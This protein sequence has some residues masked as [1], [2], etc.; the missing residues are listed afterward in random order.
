MG[1]YVKRGHTMAESVRL[2][3]DGNYA[4]G[5]AGIRGFMPLRNN[6]DVLHSTD[7][8]AFITEQGNE[9]WYYQGARYRFDGPA[10]IFARKTTSGRWKYG[11]TGEA[12][13][14]EE[15]LS[16]TTGGYQHWWHGRQVTKEEHFKLSEPW[17]M[18]KQ[19]EKEIG[20]VLDF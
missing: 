12:V 7:G 20:V 9:E 4:I 3:P 18:L 13:Y 6:D 17:R 10:L 11:D 14:V 1:V 19:A 5:Y 8:P 2:D 15:K 16:Y